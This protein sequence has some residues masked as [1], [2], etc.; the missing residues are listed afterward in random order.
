V[1]VVLKRNYGPRLIRFP[2]KKL[3]VDSGVVNLYNNACFFPGTLCRRI[4]IPNFPAAGR[5]TQGLWR[6]EGWRTI[7]M[8]YAIVENGGKQYRAIEDGT[9]MVDLMPTE[10]G[11]KVI[12]DSVL[13]TVD[14]GN[15]TVGTPTIK[16]ASVKTKVVAHEKGRKVIVFK[17]R[18]GN[19]Y[20][21]KTGHR[22]QYTR[23]KVEKIVTE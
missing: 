19:N 13:L 8:K 17:Y 4:I 3:P 7:K 2:D 20:R 16:G 18:S 14:D 10:V 15:V 23:L 9:I 21:V 6:S 22:Q 1:A 5:V 11:K 12:L